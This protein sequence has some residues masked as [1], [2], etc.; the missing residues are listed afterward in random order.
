MSVGMIHGASGQVAASLDTLR[1]RIVGFLRTSLA[2]ADRRRMPRHVVCL[3]A[4][5]QGPQDDL[6]GQMLDISYYGARFSPAG[7]LAQGSTVVLHVPGQAAQRCLVV[8]VGG[9]A[10]PDFDFADEAEQA[11]MARQVD[12]IVSSAA[13]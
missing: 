6:T 11:A 4:R 2:E 8:N 13:A 5:L 12:A 1:S 10:H 9:D 3:P 7:M